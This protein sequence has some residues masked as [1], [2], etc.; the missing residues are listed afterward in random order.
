MPDDPSEESGEIREALLTFV[1]AVIVA[2]FVN[3]ALLTYAGWDS[4]RA[5]LTSIAVGIALAL[6]LQRAVRRVE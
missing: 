5:L 3:W 1:P 2:F 4:R 6:I